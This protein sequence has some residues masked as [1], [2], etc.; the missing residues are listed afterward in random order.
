MSLDLWLKSEKC[1][2]CGRSDDPDFDWNYTYNVSKMWFEVFPN[3]DGMVDIDGL[4]GK[5]SL[6]KLETFKAAMINDPNKFKKMNPPNGWGSYTT[7][8]SAI[9]KL[10][11]AAKE[12][13][14]HIWHSWR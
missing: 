3:A 7:F 6:K 10:I 12:H 5:E 13:P 9:E 4:T 14:D 11:E 1:P 2:H 8:L